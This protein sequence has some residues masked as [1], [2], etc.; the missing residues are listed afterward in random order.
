MFCSR[1]FTFPIRDS[2]RILCSSPDV[3]EQPAERIVQEGKD[4]LVI[5]APRHGDVRGRGDIAPRIRN[6]DSRSR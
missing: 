6:L 5:Q 1:L 4:V 3:T 2:R